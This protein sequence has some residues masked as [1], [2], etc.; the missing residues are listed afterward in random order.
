MMP[1]SAFEESVLELSKDIDKDIREVIDTHAPQYRQSPPPL[2]KSI[3]KQLYMKLE[4]NTETS[5]KQV[6][7]KDAFNNE[8]WSNQVETTGDDKTSVT[9][10]DTASTPSTESIIS[11]PQHSY[12]RIGIESPDTPV[13]EGAIKEEVKTHHN[14]TAEGNSSHSTHESSIDQPQDISH[15]INNPFIMTANVSSVTTSIVTTDT[16]SIAPHTITA[17]HTITTHHTT[18][19]TSI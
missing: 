3:D 8:K 4:E 18:S 2:R 6:N 13:N 7:Y 1:G 15:P 14:P 10:L 11:F 12:D 17:S 9:T 16:L 19:P 5:L